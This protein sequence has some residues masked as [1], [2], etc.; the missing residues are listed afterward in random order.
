[1]QDNQKAANY[2]KYGQEFR[3]K[4]KVDEAIVSYKKAIEIN[5]KFSWSYFYLGE[6]LVTQGKVGEAIEA[7]SQAIE[8]NPSSPWFY[9]NLGY[10]LALQGKKGE[11]VSSYRRASELSCS[12]S[13]FFGKRLEPFLQPNGFHRNR[14]WEL[15]HLHILPSVTPFVYANDKFKFLYIPIGKTAS[16]SI[17][18]ALSKGEL[19]HGDAKKSGKSVTGLT[20]IMRTPS[21]LSDPPYSEYFKF[22]FVRNPFDKL[23]SLY[24]DRVC[25]REKDDFRSKYGL[26]RG[27][28]FC[29]Y[30]NKIL[31]SENI[32]FH[33]ELQYAH[34]LENDTV[35]TSFVG[36][37]ENLER[38]YY[39]VLSKIGLE[40]EL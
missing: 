28:S 25:R 40:T 22:T 1:M 36:R 18:S 12:S 11:A 5:P 21:L 17:I 8:L 37:F 32:D 15:S 29:E 24:L 35:V 33:Y 6:I 7:Y 14:W 39:Y 34:I 4:G 3:R 19:P 31:T 26:E 30:I 16:T 23:V 38:D 20:K 9:Y 2:I 10:A 13:I 27:A